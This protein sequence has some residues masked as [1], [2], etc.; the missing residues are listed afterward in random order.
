MERFEHHVVKLHHVA[1]TAVVD[2]EDR[3]LMMYR[4][5]FVPQQWGWELP[6]GIVDEGRTPRIRRCGR[7]WR[8]RAG[9]RSRWST[10]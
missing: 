8:K 6:G 1:V 7:S 9:G 10:S 5:R 4:Y 2:D 3:V